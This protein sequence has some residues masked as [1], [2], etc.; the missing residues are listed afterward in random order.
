MLFFFFSPLSSQLC[1]HS[2]RIV[3]HDLFCLG[4]AR[5]HHLRLLHFFA[6]LVLGCQ[7]E[8]SSI[9]QSLLKPKVWEAG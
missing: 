7:S 9:G 3:G 5:R 2:S 8:S 1:V 4:T 6:Q